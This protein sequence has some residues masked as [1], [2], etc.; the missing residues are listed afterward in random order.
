ME[1]F[2]EK[3]KGRRYYSPG[4]MGLE[5]EIKKRIDWWRNVK[6]KIREKKNSEQSREDKLEGSHSDRDKKG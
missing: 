3:L 2:P 4:E 5:K 6:E 1:T